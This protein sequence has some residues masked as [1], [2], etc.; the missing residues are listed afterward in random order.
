MR[1][2]LDQG[3]PAV[4]GRHRHH[5]QQADRPAPDYGDMIARINTPKVEEHVVGDRERFHQGALRIRQLVGDLVEPFPPSRE[6][7]GC[8]TVDVETE[9]VPAP[10]ADDTFP[11]HTV[12]GR[13]PLDRPPHLDDLHTTRGPA[14][15]DTGT[16]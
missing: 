12:S 5:T 14:S 7:L 2:R 1:L 3:D 10:L 16:G 11:D 6:H 8:G 4:A 13:N 15:P 9:V